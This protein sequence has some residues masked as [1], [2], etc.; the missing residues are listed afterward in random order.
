MNLKKIVLLFCYLF[1]T[2]SCLDD[3]DFTQLEDYNTTSV[4]TISAV[5]FTI[6]PSQFFNRFGVQIN[7]I[8]EAIKID[9]STNNSLRR[10]IVRVDFNAQIINEFDTDFILQL[11]LLDANYLPIY[12]SEEMLVKA[13]DLDY[14]FKET[15]DFTSNS[16][17]K[18]TRG[19]RLKIKNNTPSVKLNPKDRTCSIILQNYLKHYY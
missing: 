3:L 6:F 9:L 13:N 8:E 17:L 14:E 5:H 10:K 2:N 1:L 4:F 15:I 11:Q 18:D 7:E 12:E 16:A 19:S